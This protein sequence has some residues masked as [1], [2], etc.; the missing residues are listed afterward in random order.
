MA[1][2]LKQY[3][4]I[5]YVRKNSKMLRTF[6]GDFFSW[7]SEKYCAARRV[8]YYVCFLAYKPTG[9]FPRGTLAKEDEER[10]DYDIM[11][12]FGIA[13][14]RQ[15][16][17]PSRLRAGGMWHSLKVPRNSRSSVLDRFQF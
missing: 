14:P 5:I 13:G 9:R 15:S 17:P 8:D 3:T 16:A 6:L 11:L 10:R 7:F 4:E 2:S 12:G 1:S